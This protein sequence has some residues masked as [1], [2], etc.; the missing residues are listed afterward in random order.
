MDKYALFTLLWT[1]LAVPMD[2]ASARLVAALMAKIGPWFKLCVGAY[3]LIM[4]LIASWTGDADASIRLFRHALLAAIVYA[5]AFTAPAF[6]YYVTALV[7]GTTAAIS[8][9]TAD[10]FNNGAPINANAFD[11]IGTRSFAIGLAVFKNIGWNPGKAI[12]LGYVVIIY[13]Y[14][15][16]FAI[17]IT[18][19]VYLVSY[20]LGAFVMAFGPLFIPLYF[21]PFTRK[22]FDGWLSCVLATVLVQIFTAALA[23]MF[24][25]V[26]GM[27]LSLAATGLADSTLGAANGGVVIG[28]L[29]MLVITALF[30][31]IFAILAGVL[32]YVAVRI[33]GGAHAEMGRLQAPSWMPSFGG[34]GNNP[35]PPGQPHAQIAG[36]HHGGAGGGVLPGP[37]TAGLPP[38]DYAFNRNVGSAP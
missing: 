24:V 10:I 19:S 12:V 20:M 37:G 18:F 32:V 4:M 14:L 15:S 8:A 5:I 23:A 3:L 27:I 13:W 35:P 28:E 11:I 30:C 26:I 38:R 36:P 21:F 16:Y 6:D 31:C 17:V 33:T 29:M 2:A 7:H 1:N 9:A 34:G 25:F 22:Y